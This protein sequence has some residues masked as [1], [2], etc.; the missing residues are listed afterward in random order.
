[1]GK[2]G[3][4]VLAERPQRVE[5]VVEAQPGARERFAPKHPGGS[6]WK[7]MLHQAAAGDR[8]GERS[9]S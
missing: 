5:R 8:G 9:R 7:T 6:S 3:I 2:R 4:L 1:M